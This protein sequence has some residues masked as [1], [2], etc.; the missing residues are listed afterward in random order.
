[1]TLTPDFQDD[2]ESGG[3][4]GREEGKAGGARQG[5]K[6]VKSDKEKIKAATMTTPKKVTG[7]HLTVNAGCFQW[8]K[9]EVFLNNT[10]VY[11]IEK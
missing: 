6:E 11:C 3:D 2:S 8:Q 5:G 10:L 9:H 4:G 1:M 7:I